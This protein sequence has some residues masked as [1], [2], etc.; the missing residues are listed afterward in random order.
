MKRRA[1]ALFVACVPHFTAMAQSACEINDVHTNPDARYVRPAA[2]AAAEPYHT[3]RFDW[4]RA[5]W[6]IAWK[7]VPMGSVNPPPPLNADY[8]HIISPFYSNDSDLEYVA[9]HASSDMQPRDGWELVAYDFGMEYNSESTVRPLNDFSEGYLIL[10]NKYTSTLRALVTPLAINSANMAEMRWFLDSRVRGGP[11]TS[12]LFAG[13]GGVLNPLDQPSPT[14]T[15]STRFSHPPNMPGRWFHGDVPVFY[16]PCSCTTDQRLRTEHV[17]VTNGNIKLYGLYAGTVSTLDAHTDTRALPYRSGMIQDPEAYL[18]S[19]D[20]QNALD[21]RP[22]A[23]VAKDKYA[24]AQSY[25]LWVREQWNRNT[26]SLLLGIADALTVAGDVASLF[27]ASAM[28]VGVKVS[29]LLKGVG[30]ASKLLSKLLKASDDD[31]VPENYL[32]SYMQGE[33]SLRGSYTTTSPLTTNNQSIAL[34][35]TPWTKDGSLVAPFKTADKPQYPLYTETLGLFAILHAPKVKVSAGLSDVFDM[36]EP[37]ERFT[38]LK[39]QRHRWKQYQFDGEL[40]YVWNPAAHVDVE[41]TRIYAALIVEQSSPGDFTSYGGVGCSDYYDVSILNGERMYDTDVIANEPTS[42]VYSTP[43]VGLECLQDLPLGLMR[44]QICPRAHTNNSAGSFRSDDSVAIRLV[45]DV[46]FK[47][48]EY[49]VR[50]RSMMIY[51]LPVELINVDD[52]LTGS[53]MPDYAEDLTIT[54]TVLHYGDHTTYVKRTIDFA[55]ATVGTATSEVSAEYVAGEEIAIQG[56]TVIG[57]ETRLAIDLGVPCGKP[58][59]APYSGDMNA[60][61][62]SSHYRAKEL[63]EAMIAPEGNKTPTERLLPDHQLRARLEVSEQHLNV[64]SESTEDPTV[65]VQVYNVI[66]NLVARGQGYKSAEPLIRTT[67][68]MNDVPAGAYVVVATSGGKRISFN[69]LYAPW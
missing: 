48:N 12:G 13:T 14:R 42:S 67:V 31:I 64:V 32:P 65:I 6:P 26:G 58:R 9:K 4:I 49:G 33:I 47:P 68:V 57:T 63:A 44:G 39:I 28:L 24:L 37:H 3:N 45:M 5:W 38:H 1:A 36:T 51:T 2:E 22:G 17:V 69:T 61:C 46:R 16:D 7:N 29:L 23:I 30:V 10:Y 25:D 55:N 19:L 21:L 53:G 34:P 41:N 35:G 18:A 40:D 59:V 15:V 20:A 52:T 11:H 8:M 50:N 27:G 43:F 60:F 54:G 56:E 66:G 62:A